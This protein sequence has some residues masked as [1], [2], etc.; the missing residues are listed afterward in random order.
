MNY[1]Q[2]E[3]YERQYR[4]WKM[5]LWI[6][7]TIALVLFL[8]L[9]QFIGFAVQR[10]HLNKTV[11]ES[12]AQMAQI[13]FNIRV[14]YSIHNTTPI[15]SAQKMVEIGAI[16]TSLF[17]N[18]VIANPFG[19]KIV[20]E[21]AKPFHNK[22]D[23]V[24]LP[25]FKISYQGLSHEACI[26]LATIDWNQNKQGLVAMAVGKVNEYGIDTALRDVD[27]SLATQNI[28]EITG[29]DG[30]KH[31][32]RSA[33]IYKMNVA[34]PQSSLS[35]IPFS[36][37]AASVAC[38]CRQYANCSFALNYTLSGYFRTQN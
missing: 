25:T 37:T 22:E 1:T 30:K 5:F 12:V 16:P 31:S 8:K 9:C 35:P 14:F 38:E 20:I 33:V 23:N 4:I 10:Y 13:I 36:E 11:R 27:D 28:V 3:L 7:G 26:K 2:K 18:Q 19:G 29:D 34:K 32:V 24:L 21:Q 6:A 15:S 17:K